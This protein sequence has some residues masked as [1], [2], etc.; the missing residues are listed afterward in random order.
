VGEIIS[1]SVGGFI[2]ERW[3]ASPGIRTSGLFAVALGNNSF[4]A[5]EL[6]DRFPS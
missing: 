6:T 5:R 1:E 2:P 4:R 3:A